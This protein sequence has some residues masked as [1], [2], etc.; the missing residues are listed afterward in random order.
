MLIFI[1]LLSNFQN[2]S[3]EMSMSMWQWGSKAI[4]IGF[5]IQKKTNI[6]FFLPTS[7]AGGFWAFMQPGWDTSQARNSPGDPGGTYDV[8][9]LETK[10]KN[11]L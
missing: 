5:L 1:I 8:K 3:F 10:F 7:E 9:P 2:L 4:F 6:H 11:W